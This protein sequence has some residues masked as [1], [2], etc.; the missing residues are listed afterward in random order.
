MKYTY[1]TRMAIPFIGIAFGFFI[2]CSTLSGNKTESDGSLSQ[3]DLK[4]RL[5]KIEANIS[6]NPD[7]AEA[8]YQK[9]DVLS[10]LAQ[11]QNP[12]A[13]R[14]SYYQ[15]M[16]NALA[17]ASAIHQSGSQTQGEEK[18]DELLQVNWSFEH[19]Q[20]VKILQTDST[21]NNND[22]NNAADH[23]NNALIIIP[24][25]AV[26]YKMK[27]RALYKNHKID[28]AI[29]TLNTAR[30]RVED[31]PTSYIEQLAYLYLESNQTQRAIDL[32]EEAESFSSDNLNLLHGL[33]N[34]YITADQHKEAIKLLGTLV[35]NKPENIIYLESYGTELYSVGMQQLDS[36]QSFNAEDSLA[37]QQT[38]ASADT[39]LNMAKNQLR[40]ILNQNPDKTEIKQQ[41]A[42]INKNYA[43]KLSQIKSLYSQSKQQEIENQI[44]NSLSNAVNLYEELVEQQPD[45]TEFWKHLYQA[46]SYLGM[47]EQANEA[48][49]KANL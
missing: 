45:K 1:F 27:A 22:L 24:D 7:N 43:A 29:Q 17:K 41:L 39:L 10:K 21:L 4:K 19:N 31:L 2:G 26:S 11:R 18:I 15:E 23:F 48:K 38:K 8:Y 5:S 25:S 44:Q 6:S 13:K 40:K 14:A 35:E 37:I 46:Y 28:E 33:A 9:G 20:G 32:Y 36:L 12:P 42:D 16:Q 49:A 47:Q 34:A 30:N 3:K